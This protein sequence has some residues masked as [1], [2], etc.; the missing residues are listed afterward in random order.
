MPTLWVS[1]CTQ[2]IS[3][4]LFAAPLSAW[5]QA[6]YNVPVNPV[7]Q[8]LVGAVDQSALNDPI[9]PAH[10]L[11][12]VGNRFM[13]IGPDLSRGTA[14]DKRVRLFGINLTR[15]ACFPSF[16]KA[17]EIAATLR[18]LGFN[19]VRLH[20]MDAA[21][22]SDP[23]VFR[24]SLTTEPYPTLHMGAI[25]RLRH[26]IAAL[27]AEG[28]YTNLN[29]MVGYVFRP[30]VDGV[31]ALDTKGTAPGY[32]SPVHVFFPRMVELQIEHAQ[33]LLAALGLKNEPALAQVEITNESSLAAAWLHWDKTYWEQQIQGEYALELDRQW[34]T[35]IQQEHG[36]V[37]VACKQWGTC[38]N[39][40]G[41]M[42][43]PAEAEALQHMLSA[44]WWL[45]LKQRW[46]QWMAELRTYLG[47]TVQRTEPL[48]KAH[49]K[50]KDALR[51]IAA[52]DR[53]F[54]EKLRSAV[55]NATRLDLPVG[56]TQMDFGA[57]LNFESHQ[58]MDFVDTH[59]YVDHP[60][61]PAEPWSETNWYFQNHSVSGREIGEL[62]RLV[63]VRDSKKPFV[64][65]EYNQPFPNPQGHDI[66]PLTAAFAAQQD[67]DGL[68]FYDY[69]AN[70]NRENTPANF[71][72]QGE[73]AKTNV[74]GIAAQLFRTGVLPA[75]KN[76]HHIATTSEHGV[77][78]V[79]QERRPDAWLRHLTHQ[80]QFSHT[81]AMSRLIS[82]DTSRPTLEPLIA[83]EP[84]L[85]HRA[86]ERR[87]SIETPTIHASLGEMNPQQR[88]TVGTLSVQLQAHAPS[89]AASVI[90]QSLD[91]L[92]LTASRHMLLATPAPFSGSHPGESVLRPQRR[93]PYQGQA[94]K[95]TLEPQTTHGAKALSGARSAISPLWMERQPM[96]VSIATK[97][98]NALV[99]PLS[100][101]GTRLPAL[102][103]SV[104]KRH[105]TGVE[106]SLNQV[107]SPPSMWHEIVLQ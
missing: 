85:K 17:T 48:Q 10:S 49:P 31:P 71:S 81:L 55:Q 3:V 95:W 51:F 66:L 93:I 20:Q 52:T 29:L 91:G 23:N 13:T 45:R 104:V 60:V 58:A 37:A 56:G 43:T 26:L 57:P 65:S 103:A 11:G 86:D 9:T 14:D 21:P 61:F 68:F 19:A 89:I 42:P 99:Y 88:T 50:V 64:V 73:W 7:W 24:S 33:K 90:L 35:W 79:A 53:Q 84:M 67:W 46:H 47:L 32:G 62:L 25:Q 28:L 80:Q 1:W 41:R 75:L 101:N 36:T 2:L 72:L 107:R 74:V 98:T 34:Q 100:F 96:T 18:S 15:D 12:V 83:E 30:A 97:H 6:S 38:S 44:H 87:A 92:P 5:A 63:T 27:K 82:V 94:G 54:F 78:V 70:T 16:D 39:E 69:S 102:D 77:D 59:F 22:S 4:F 40:T 106:L 105:T 8:R 76:R